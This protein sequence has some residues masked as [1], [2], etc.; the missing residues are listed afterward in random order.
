MNTDEI[1]WSEENSYDEEFDSYVENSKIEK[2]I[3]TYEEAKITAKNIVEKL[4]PYSTDSGYD[5]LK[6][7]IKRKIALKKRIDYYLNNCEKFGFNQTNKIILENAIDEF[8]KPKIELNEIDLDEDLTLTSFDWISRGLGLAAGDSI[9]LVGEAFCGKTHFAS[10]LALCVAKGVSIFGKFKIDKSGPVAHLNYDSADDMTRVGYVRLKNGDSDLTSSGNK[11]Q[12]GRPQWR[13]N[14]D[15]AYENLTKICTGKVLCVVD[16]LRRSY[17]GSDSDTDENSSASAEVVD[18][19][20]RVSAETGCAI[21]FIAHPGKGGTKGKGIDAVRGS[22][23]IKDVAGS[24]WILEKTSTDQV[25]KFDS[26]H[27]SRCGIKQIFHYR[28]DNVGD[29]CEGIARTKGIRM[30]ILEDN[31]TVL[32]KKLTIREQIVMALKN[33]SLT[34]G[35][36]NKSITG[37]RLK[38]C[39]ELRKMESEG[40][41]KKERD[42]KSQKYSLTDKGAWL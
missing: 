31:T 19:A 23:A 32:E 39:D 21:L 42:G 7:E 1:D 33:E 35:D 6:K 34:S 11:V 8:N 24:L 3:S 41:L 10:Y 15:C 2:M 20:N 4:T 12:Y 27:K 5:R 9:V 22:S 18:L 30:T 37:A 16:S 26:M 25:I 17:G 14:Q 28:Y 29:Y 40:F 13:F 38:I 36:L